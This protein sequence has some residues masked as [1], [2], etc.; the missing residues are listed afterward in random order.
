MFNCRCVPWS[1]AGGLGVVAYVAI[2]CGIDA[3][4]TTASAQSNSAAMAAVPVQIA[5]PKRED[6][7][8][9]LSGIGAAQAN[10]SVGITSQ[11]DGELQS[12]HFTE[13]QIVKQGDLLAVI[14]P[15]PFQAALDQA[16]AKIRQDEAD[17]ENARYLLEK[18]TTLAAQQIVTQEALEQQ[19]AVVKNLEALVSSD[20]AA[21]EAAE[22]SLSYTQIKSPIDGI[23]GILAVDPGNQVRASS[24]SAI[25]TIT[26]VKPISVIFSLKE[27]DI[28][29][30][31]K[32]MAA[33]AV[34]VT[35]KSIDQS[36]LLG[37]GTVTLIDNQIDEA[38]GSLRLKSSFANADLSLWPGEAVSISLR[39]S[40]LPNSLTI[41]SPAVQRG[42]DGFFVYVIDAKGQAEITKIT[43]RQIEE[44]RAVVSSGLI[45]SEKVVVTGQY[46][47][48]PG[49][50]VDATEYVAMAMDKD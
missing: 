39:Q 8:I 13:G 48:S 1:L 27:T 29:E 17:L 2:T 31:R 12:V 34:P 40:I 35:A 41:P 16:Q 45:G 47:L 37:T 42:P 21:K 3:G 43:V 32:A 5:V 10:A 18:D 30:V 14:D 44:G 50:K 19:R 6:V 11:V 22:V 49:A 4:V 33:G 26:Q 15:R 23:T 36:R 7:A 9:Y 20:T 46:R 25:V 24:S 28:D 38:T